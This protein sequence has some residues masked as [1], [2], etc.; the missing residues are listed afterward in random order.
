MRIANREEL[1]EYRKK[2]PVWFIVSLFLSIILVWICVGAWIYTGYRIGRM[3]TVE[4][5]KNPLVAI[6]LMGGLFGAGSVAIGLDLIATHFLHK[7]APDYPEERLGRKSLLVLIFGGITVCA[8]C[9]A[10]MYIMLIT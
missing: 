1:K 2:H 6:P 9:G 3:A 7:I 10:V 5:A 8:I 4:N